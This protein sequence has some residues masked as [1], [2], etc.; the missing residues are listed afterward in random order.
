[1]EHYDLVVTPPAARAL[2]QSLPKN[3]AAA[4]IHFLTGPLIANPR[5]VGKELRRELAGVYSARRGTYRILLRIDD[6]AR[7]VVILRIEQ[8]RD[9]YR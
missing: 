6:G 1:M 8:R 9:V 2:Q 4:V 7:E 3:V 5:R